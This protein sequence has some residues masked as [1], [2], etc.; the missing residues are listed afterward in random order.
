VISGLGRGVN[1]MLN[2][3]VSVQI[4]GPVFKDKVT[5]HNSMTSNI[6]ED[7]T[8]ITDSTR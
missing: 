8:N 7:Q 4:I 2:T 1:E 3:V 5:K 6:L